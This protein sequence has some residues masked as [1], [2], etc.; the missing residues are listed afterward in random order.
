M[1]GVN[2]SMANLSATDMSE[3]FLTGA[4]MPD[5]SLHS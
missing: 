5:G 2:F 4:I 3:T 1:C